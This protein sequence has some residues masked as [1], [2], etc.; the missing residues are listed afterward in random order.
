M[1]LELVRAYTCNC[2]YGLK[3]SNPQLEK[4]F[5]SDFLKKWCRL[6]RNAYFPKPKKF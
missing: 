3:L 2:Y 6:S 5:D 1:S 4:Q